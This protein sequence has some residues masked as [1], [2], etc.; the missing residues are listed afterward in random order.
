MTFSL[1]HAR[2]RLHA[3]NFAMAVFEVSLSFPYFSIAVHRLLN[4]LWSLR[5][6]FLSLMLVHLDTWFHVQDA[7]D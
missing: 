6:P 1:C 3:L 5:A 4:A 2:K 7:N